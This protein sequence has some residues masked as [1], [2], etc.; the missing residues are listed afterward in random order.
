MKAWIMLA[1]RQVAPPTLCQ[2]SSELCSACTCVMR[3]P[4]PSGVTVPLL[5]MR[6]ANVAGSSPSVTSD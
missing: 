1:R 2:T 6:L 4:G 5:F 3:M